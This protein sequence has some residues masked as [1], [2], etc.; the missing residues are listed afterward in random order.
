MRHCYSGTA[1]CALPDLDTRDIYTSFASGEDTS[2]QREGHITST[3]RSTDITGA[4]ISRII[5]ESS[6]SRE[7]Q[8]GHYYQTVRLLRDQKKNHAE[9]PVSEETQT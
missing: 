4:A 9:G 7:A 6:G 5:S 2:P 8:R 3:E 1:G